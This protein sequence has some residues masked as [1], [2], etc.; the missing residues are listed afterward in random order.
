DVLA[1]AVGGRLRIKQDDGF[2]KDKWSLV[3]NAA[4][5]PLAG[6]GL[7]NSIPQRALLSGL[8][9]DGEESLELKDTNASI[10]SSARAEHRDA[11]DSEFQPRYFKRNG[12]KVAIAVLIAIVTTIAAFV[13]SGGYG[14]PAIVAAAVVMLLSLVIFG[15]LVRAPTQEGRE[16][17][18]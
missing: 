1:L 2:F 5:R 4:P 7:G 14:L 8:F 6:N 9:P 12:K 18:D 15:R 3:R 16:L 13:V 17:L 10:V 11:L